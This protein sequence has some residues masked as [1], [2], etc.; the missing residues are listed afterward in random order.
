MSATRKKQNAK[1]KRI[2]IVS[3][4]IALILV[5][6]STFA[7]FTSTDS[8][9][10]RLTASSDY[11]VSITETFTPPE[12]WVPGQEIN[13]DVGAVNT[14]NISAF[15]RL[16]LSNN[17]QVTT[18]EDVAESSFDADKCI[19]LD[20][21][22][23]SNGVT[24]ANEVLALQSG[25]LLV[26]A[27]QGET[28]GSLATYY[29]ND[30]NNSTNNK[31][32]K[33]GVYIF[34]HYVETNTTTDATTGKKTTT[35]TYEYKGF[36]Y[37]SKTGK[38]YKINVTCSDQPDYGEDLNTVTD[39]KND[40]IADTNTGAN[41]SFTVTYVKESD[42][43]NTVPTFT[44][45]AAKGEIT[46]SNGNAVKD[47]D[48]NLTYA[49]PHTNE[50]H[51][52][53]IVA[54]YDPKNN[55]SSSDTDRYDDDIV[56]YINLK[57]GAVGSDNKIGTAG[58]AWTYGGLNSTSDKAY[59]FLN[60]ILAPGTSS[61][62][63]LVDSVEL[64]SDI[65]DG[66]YANLTYDLN[67]GL[68]SVQAVY[69]QETDGTTTIDTASSKTAAETLTKTTA[70]GGTYNVDSGLTT[71]TITKETDNNNKTWWKVVWSKQ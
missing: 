42:P 41:A 4:A 14:G 18:Y 22:K 35:Y 36:R 27:P 5:I 23:T 55:D 65:K 45:E 62:T 52:D 51:P 71:A 9:T 25:G 2:L 46:D 50:S 24:P 20:D 19:T 67:I 33:D 63:D 60:E 47:S 7:W 15:V 39:S 44:F 30:P 49:T 16:A 68:S 29:N 57:D 10:N 34:R 8:V 31:I 53:R 40:G 6:G 43:V 56:I 66:A 64:S 32:P 61:S 3:L 59:F 58:G 37:D 69:E 1:Q 38:Y 13:K 12:D 26:S 48:G 17:L 11:G 28:L 21:G 70:D 54:T